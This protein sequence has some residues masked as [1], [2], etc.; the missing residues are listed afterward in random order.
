MLYCILRLAW[1]TRVGELWRC[2]SLSSD[3]VIITSVHSDPA[4]EIGIPLTLFSFELRDMD[5]VEELS[6]QLARQDTQLSVLHKLLQQSARG[7]DISSSAERVVRY[8]L[9]SSS[10]TT[11]QILSLSLDVLCASPSHAF[12]VDALSV[13]IENLQ[14]SGTSACLTVLGKIRALPHAAL[15]H[16]ILYAATPLIQALGEDRSPAIR[17]AA[18]FA[19]AASV[20]RGKPLTASSTEPIRLEQLNQDQIAVLKRSI[21]R[22]LFALLLAIFDR[23]DEVAVT[24]LSLLTKFSIDADATL[25]RSVLNRTKEATAGAIWDILTS[26]C[27]NVADRFNPL[28]GKLGKADTSD[29]STAAGREVFK[30]RKEA[31]KSLTR[32]AARAL[33]EKYISIEEREQQQD[34]LQVATITPALMSAHDSLKWGLTWVDNVL[35]PLCDNA[36]V[37]VAAA[38]CSAM[39]LV[40]SYAVQNPS[41]EKVAQW[42]IKAVRRISRL[43]FESDGRISIIVM[44][45][46]V[47]DASHGLAALSKND[48]VTS[49]FVVTIATGLIPFAAKCPR[50]EMRLEAMSVI[51]STIIEYDLS[52]R[53]AGVGVSLKAVLSSDAWKSTMVAGKT[54]SNVASELV[55]CFSQ[56]ILESS[57]KIFACQDQE[58]RLSL[59]HTWAVMLSQLMG[60]THMCLSWPYSPASTYARELYLKVF[61]ALGQYSAFLMRAQGVGMEEYERLQE[62][63]AK[64]TLEQNDVAARASLLI[65]ITKYW[66]TSGIKAESNAGHVLK[67]IWKHV[68]E[69]YRDEEIMLTELKTGALWSDARQ[70]SRTPAERA[71]EGGYVSIAT[72]LSKRTRSIIDT[73]GMSV[74]TAIESTLFGSIALA[75][76]AAEGSTLTTD[77]A[78]A[79]L[80]ALLALVG[81]NPAIAEKGVKILKKYIGIMEEAES[82]DFIVLE[83]V[84][85]TIAAIEMYQDEFF[86]RPVMP[87][88]L[89]GL[90][91]VSN[92]QQLQERNDSLSW[93]RDITESCVFATSRLED[94]SKESSTVSAEEVILHTA[95]ITKK[96]MYAF[97]PV[98]LQTYDSSTRP[99]TE[100]DQQTL[101][102]ASDP[103]SVVASHSMDT[104][105]GLA[106]LRVD[107]INRSAFKVIN[108]A[109]TYS[110]SG[111]L[112]PLPDAAT[113]YP[114]GTMAHGMAVTQRITLSVRTN[115]GFAGRV[116]FSIHTRREG[117]D[118]GTTQEQCCVPYYIPS[119]DV[120]LLRKPAPNAGVDVF[121]RR[122]DL[123]RHSISFQVVIRK[124]QSVDSFVDTLERRS[125]CLRQVGRMRTYSHVCALVADSSREDYVAVALLAPEAQGSS[126]R[127]PCMIYGTIRSNSAGYNHA[128]REEC[129]E[130]LSARFRIIFPDDDLTDEAKGFALKPQDAYFIT[131]SPDNLSPYQRWR[132]AHSVRVTY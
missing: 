119:S 57:R 25:E 88:E 75:T 8:C 106:L 54:D 7:I 40:C 90:S 117:S 101:N 35:A 89:P 62:S 131:N 87:R 64:E 23:A 44:T 12:W 130:W 43:L 112:V 17:K 124:N 4:S 2:I 15:Q 49:K 129:R 53:D 16:L 41:L 95:A 51:A 107:V 13:I 118:D 83:A 85:N 55:C 63:L 91:S 73:V 121:R 20:L 92:R 42:G 31:M 29:K 27:K 46:L 69:H 18:A 109:L 108:A 70:G 33:N 74:S 36:G 123:M 52:G 50:R 126:G 102:G 6:K 34:A 113:W 128:F 98:T 104:V 61:D 1:A 80:S 120:L 68:Q 81:H 21:E 5:I 86:P 22:L 110:S 26:N 82:S 122:W 14:R 10:G 71:V 24:A 38:A 37:E 100:G 3:T 65:C 9:F 58:L 79:G 45:G 78:Y 11:P 84:R 94:P 97:S 56:S 96:R 28:L 47:R 67:A 114:L 105:K 32:L 115:Q 116:F 127:G 60:R 132:M 99:I 30:F 76:A 48:Y 72:A 66:L 111:A 39:L 125:K 19:V 77:F 93:M 59:T 103:F